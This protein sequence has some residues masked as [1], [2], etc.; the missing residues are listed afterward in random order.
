M[1]KEFMNILMM[2]SIVKETNFMY[3]FNKY[4]KIAKQKKRN[5]LLYTITFDVK[6]FHD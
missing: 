5:S 3:N 1:R 6:L 4:N 2:L